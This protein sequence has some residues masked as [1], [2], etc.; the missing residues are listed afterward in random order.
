[1]HH[2]FCTRLAGDYR[3]LPQYKRFKPDHIAKLV[4][5][6]FDF[7]S[8]FYEAQ[9]VDQPFTVRLLYGKIYADIVQSHAYPSW[10]QPCLEEAEYYRYDNLPLERPLALHRIDADDQYSVDFFERFSREFQDWDAV[11]QHKLYLQYDVNRQQTSKV[12]RMGGPHY[13]SNVIQHPGAA[14]EEDFLPMRT[15]HGGISKLFRCRNSDECDVLALEAVGRSNVVNRWKGKD[16][17]DTR[18]P[19][20][21]YDAVRSPV[22]T[23]FSPQ[24]FL[25]G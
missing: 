3:H 8:K 14:T 12:Q 22:P 16:P 10:A 20:F 9:T 15:M 19:R 6:W 18:H 13:F 2:V 5:F 1:M 25:A 24:P 11:V 23:K 21:I 17:T 4:Q 7:G